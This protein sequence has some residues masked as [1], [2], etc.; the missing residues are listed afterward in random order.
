MQIAASILPLSSRES[1][2]IVFL[3]LYQETLN[4]DP[5]NTYAPASTPLVIS[6]RGRGPSSSNDVQLHS[7]DDDESRVKA[8]VRK[9]ELVNELTTMVAVSTHLKRTC[10]SV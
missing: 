2:N 5:H 3:E 7:C 4:V 8:T 6:P 9:T 10:F 1:Q